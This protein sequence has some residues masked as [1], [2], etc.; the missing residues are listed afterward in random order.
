[1]SISSVLVYSGF[2]SDRV[3]KD[4]NHP[5]GAKREARGVG[6]RGRGTV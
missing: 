2:P 3:V 4:S 5:D 1:V 6:G